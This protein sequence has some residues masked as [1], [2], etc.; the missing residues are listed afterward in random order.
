MRN[1]LGVK[2]KVTGRIGVIY[3]GGD[4]EDNGSSLCTSWVRPRDMFD[5]IASGDRQGDVAGVDPDSLGKNPGNGKWRSYRDVG[6]WLSDQSPADDVHYAIYHDG[7]RWL[8]KPLWV[9]QDDWRD[10]AYEVIDVLE[11][12]MAHVF[13]SIEEDVKKVRDIYEHYT[14]YG[15]TEY[16]DAV[17][18][19]RRTQH[20]LLTM[21]DSV[22]RAPPLKSRAS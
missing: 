12:D 13:E 11:W 2:G 1:T 3:V 7:E 20:L 16:A 19:L 4:I 6:A 18:H 22:L 15:M 21:P 9:D 5:L 10:L 14:R 17:M 8:Y